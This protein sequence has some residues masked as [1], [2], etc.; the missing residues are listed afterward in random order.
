MKYFGKK[1][2]IVSA[3][4]NRSNK[5]LNAFMTM[6]LYVLYLSVPVDLSFVTLFWFP[7]PILQPKNARLTK[8]ILCVVLCSMA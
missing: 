3:R 4:Y 8:T 1:L 6:V 2:W 7:V 5:F